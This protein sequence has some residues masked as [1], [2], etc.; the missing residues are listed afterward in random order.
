MDNQKPARGRSLDAPMTSMMFDGQ[1]YPLRF[2][3]NAFRIA[4]DVYDEEY[5]KDLNFAQIA[6]Q[7]GK[8][9]LGAIMAVFY[10]GMRSA[11]A[12]ITWANFAA[13]F[14]LT[15]IPGVREKLIEMVADALP[16]PEGPDKDPTRTAQGGAD[17][18]SSPGTDSGTSQ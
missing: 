2:D 6:A 1:E 18:G 7:L 13:V 10:A 16:D 15:D 3:L 5:G 14:Q 11:G 4:E 8:G 12:E 9:R 17:P